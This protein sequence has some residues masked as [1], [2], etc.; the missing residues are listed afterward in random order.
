[1]SM[2]TREEILSMLDMGN[3]P[4]QVPPLPKKGTPVQI[5]VRISEGVTLGRLTWY[6]AGEIYRVFNKLY[7][8][9]Y[10]GNP[11]F[12]AQLSKAGNAEYG[13]GL[14]DCEILKPG[15]LITR[16][17]PEYTLED[18]EKKVGHEFTLKIKST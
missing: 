5:F 12:V 6:K 13:I 10:S 4:E 17:I 8:G 3:Y 2:K 14:G 16:P 1:M 15:E 11:H 7:W 18:L 9:F